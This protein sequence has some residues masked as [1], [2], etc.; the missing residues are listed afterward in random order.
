VL[1][2]AVL[3]CAVLC[4]AVL[5]CAVLCCAV[6]CCFLHSGIGAVAHFLIWL[7]L[8]EKTCAGCKFFFAE[9]SNDGK[10]CIMQCIKVR[11]TFCTKLTHAFLL[12]L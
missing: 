1:C 7:I 10:K 9:R 12:R 5:C 3:C 6:L 2:C 8:R 11:G 4:C